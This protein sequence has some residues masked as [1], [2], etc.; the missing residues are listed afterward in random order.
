[1]TN[2]NANGESQIT[3]P[4]IL[5]SDIHIQHMAD[6]RARLL[7]DVLE[8][9]GPQVDTVVLNGDI[10]DFCFGDSDYFRRKFR[11]LGEALMAL[12]KRGIRVVYVVGNHEFHL[13]RIGWDGVEIVQQRDIFINL[14]S[15]ARFKLT[16]GDL[17]TDEPL[18][19]LFRGTLKSQAVRFAATYIPGSWLD[20][21]SLRHAKFSRAQDQYRTLNHGR[22]LDAFARW[23][24]EGECDHGIIGHFHVPY[25]EKHPRTAQQLLSV[26]SWDRPN[27]LVFQ[28]GAFQRI[29][30]QEPGLP[31]VRQ[32][33]SSIFS[34][35]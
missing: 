1:M 19:K 16:H 9:L 22:I 4:F 25:A 31:F 30:L 27:L 20:A 10:C 11:P 15:G 2:F 6:K 7:L 24:G 18:Y 29:L 32:P 35:G 5:A 13:K 26:E 14:K 23:V 8:R 21:Y 17:L 28:D 3:A 12:A 33:I 34:G